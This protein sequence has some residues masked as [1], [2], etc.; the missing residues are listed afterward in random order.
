MITVKVFD[1]NMNKAI[2]K[3]KSILVNE[4]LFKELKDRKYYAKPSRKKKL[5]REESAK[6][7]QRDLKR[8]LKSLERDELSYF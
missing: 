3:L 2:I 6:Q 8:E 5:K 4:G 7:R 1:R